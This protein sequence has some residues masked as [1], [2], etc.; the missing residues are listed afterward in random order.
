MCPRPP[1]TSF[2]ARWRK[3]AQSSKGPLRASERARERERVGVC[4]PN[5]RRSCQYLVSKLKL[6]LSFRS[7]CHKLAPLSL[8]RSLIHTH[9]RNFGTNFS[10]FTRLPSLADNKM[11]A[12]RPMFWC[13]NQTGPEMGASSIS[14]F[15][16]PPCCCYWR[17]CSYSSQDSEAILIS[18]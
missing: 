18:A 1:E 13:D 11:R 10:C 7:S 16:W 12:A 14:Q 9:L 2:L 8:P 3:E 17:R 4:C 15:T 6:V 5:R